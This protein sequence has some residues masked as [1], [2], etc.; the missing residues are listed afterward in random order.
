MQFNI[1]VKKPNYRAQLLRESRENK[2]LAGQKKT[3]RI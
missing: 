2:F 3:V 1:K